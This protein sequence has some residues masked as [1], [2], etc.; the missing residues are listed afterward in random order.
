MESLPVALNLYNWNDLRLIAR[1]YGLYQEREKVLKR[2]AAER[3]S[4]KIPRRAGSR[5]AIRSLTKSQRA[6]LALLIQL[7][8]SAQQFALLKP[9]VLSGLVRLPTAA[10]GAGDLSLLNTEIRA[11]LEQGLVFNINSRR[12]NSLRTFSPLGE[13]AIPAEVMLVLPRDLLFVPSPKL[14]K[15]SSPPPTR[16]DAADPVVFLRRLFFVWAELRREPGTLR[17]AGGLYK[18]DVTRLATSMGAKLTGEKEAE[19]R[20][21]VIFLQWMNLLHPQGKT[22]VVPASKTDGAFWQQPLTAQFREVIA[23]LSAHGQGLSLNLQAVNATQWGYYNTPDPYPPAYL[24]KR[25]IEFLEELPGVGWLSFSTTLTLLNGGQSGHFV[26]AVEAVKRLFQKATQ[27]NWRDRGQK[28]KQQLVPALMELEKDLLRQVLASL[29][30][31]GL[32]E[33]GYNNNRGNTLPVVWRLSPLATALFAQ[34]PF[35]EPA[36]VGQIVLQPDFHLLA[37]GPVPLKTLVELEQLAERE[38]IQPAAVS[39]RVTKASIY[40]ALQDGQTVRGIL[41]YLE[42]ATLLPVSQNVRRTLQE[43]GAQH[44]RIIIHQDVLVVQMDQAALLKAL[45]ALPYLA[46]VLHP[47]DDCTAWLYSRHAKRVQRALREQKIL[48]AR[49]QGPAEDLP[50]SLQWQDETLCSRA[51]LPSLYVTGNICRVA[52]KAATGWQLTPESVRAA[53]AAGQSAPEIGALLAQ[54]TGEQ[55]PDIWE[56]RLKAWGKHFG[57][58][59]TAQVRLLRFQ[60]A[61]TLAEL[62]RSDRGLSRWLRP[63]HK[64]ESDVAVIQEKHWE[65]VGERLA[66]WG[67]AIEEER[68]W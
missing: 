6:I 21:D 61:A 19:I 17:K 10:G 60:D 5:K 39:Y 7:G 41:S 24:F 27:Y 18:R 57:A 4:Q 50:S 28:R 65:K 59:Q 9:L 49:S 53:T 26:F 34:Q 29:H 36:E 42:A 3:L 62:R 56:Q 30:E 67:V 15:Y 33:L 45:L 13:L 64:H 38:K 37:L 48:P 1:E 25:V 43:W 11:L 22:I 46:R 66:E 52:E 54:M 44:E 2:W 14:N 58:A 31:F 12:D 20:E 47:V 68:W 63:L 23:I 16:V 40:R 55:L 8:G 32:V 51:P 35:A